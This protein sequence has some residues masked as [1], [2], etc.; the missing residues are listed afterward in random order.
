VPEVVAQGGI[1]GSDSALGY[2]FGGVSG[3]GK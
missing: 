1:G 2:H 3:R